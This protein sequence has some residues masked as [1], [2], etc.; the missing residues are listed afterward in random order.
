[1]PVL[2][3]DSRLGAESQ[4]GATY[5]PMVPDGSKDYTFLKEIFT[6]SIKTVLRERKNKR[7]SFFTL[8]LIKLKKG[9]IELPRLP[10]A[11]GLFTHK[12]PL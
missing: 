7:H 12:R 1:M 5:G 9:E 2:F 10:V 3:T 6:T 8:F 11:I 4:K